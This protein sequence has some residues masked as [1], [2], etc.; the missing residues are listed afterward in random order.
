VGLS[1]FGN[2]ERVGVRV[3]V[4]V[5]GVGQKEKP[6]HARRANW[7]LVSGSVFFNGAAKAAVDKVVALWE[8]K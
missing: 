2:A 8:K 1:A 4:G 6:T 3:D 7:E 5:S